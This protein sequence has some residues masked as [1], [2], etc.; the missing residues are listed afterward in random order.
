[1]RTP[2]LMILC[3]CL[4]GA[5][6]SESSGSF[7]PGKTTMPQL[8]ERLGQPTMVWSEG[9]GSLLLEFARVGE[10]GSNFMA[11]VA[12]NGLL[13]SLQQVLT[14]A[15]VEGLVPGMSREQVRRYL[16]LPAKIETLS[17][18]EVWHWPLDSHHPPEWQVNAHFGARGSLERIERGRIHLE[19]RQDEALLAGQNAGPQL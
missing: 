10:G 18:E 15:R 3:A 19:R 14:E 8:L 17:A 6:L 16:G 9:D 4:L 1:M 11:R 12:P 13:L 7:E 5:C 2:V